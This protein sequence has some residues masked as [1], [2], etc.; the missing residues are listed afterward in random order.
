M[1]IRRFLIS[2]LDSSCFTIVLLISLLLSSCLSR[3]ALTTSF[4]FFRSFSV[5]RTREVEV[6]GA[7]ESE[8][9]LPRMSSE[10]VT[11]TDGSSTNVLEDC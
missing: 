3:R 1:F 6:E 9:A 5:S 7:T 10:L 4:S 8:G 2:K 11:S